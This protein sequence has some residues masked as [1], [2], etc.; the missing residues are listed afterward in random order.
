M[1]F[2]Y[3][4]ADRPPVW[5]Q[6]VPARENTA[7]PVEDAATTERMVHVDMAERKSAQVPEQLPVEIESPAVEAAHEEVAGVHISSVEQ[8]S[9]LT[10]CQH[11]R[12][13]DLWSSGSLTSVVP[14]RTGDVE[15]KSFISNVIERV[16]PD[17]CRPSLGRL[18]ESHEEIA[19][20]TTT[21]H[22]RDVVVVEP[23]LR[24]GQRGSWNDCL[25]PPVRGF[26]RLLRPNLSDRPKMSSAVESKCRNDQPSRPLISCFLWRDSLAT[27]HQGVVKRGTTGPN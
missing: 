6:F 7:R 2:S 26:D 21:G 3:V 9:P 16:A 22:C 25:M 17:R 1:T 13:S 18:F 4:P 11:Q 20:M 19:L 10:N 14:A 24:A 8:I 15:E 23:S 12:S 27:V 5:M